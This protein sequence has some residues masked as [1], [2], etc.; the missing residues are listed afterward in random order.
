MVLHRFPFPFWPREAFPFPSGSTPPPTSYPVL[1][2]FIG[3]VSPLLRRLNPHRMQHRSRQH[4]YPGGS[5]AVTGR[6]LYYVKRVFGVCGLRCCTVTLE[7]QRP[8]CSPMM[9]LFLSVTLR[10]LRFKLCAKWNRWTKK[11]SKISA[12]TKNEHLPTIPLILS[13]AA[14]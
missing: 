9:F 7:H 12:T 3:I 8:V 1:A 14:Q 5:I 6:G 4:A 10:V 2:G 11:V 13:S